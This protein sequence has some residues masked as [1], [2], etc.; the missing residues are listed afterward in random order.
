MVA[1]E[2]VGAVGVSGAVGLD[3]V[4]ESGVACG[5]EQSGHQV[6]IAV[7]LWGG[8]A[9]EECLHLLGVV[10]HFV[11]LFPKIGTNQFEGEETGGVIGVLHVDA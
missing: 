5:D 6:G 11:F 2:D 4:A 8:L 3:G 7:G 10:L 1:S 9:I